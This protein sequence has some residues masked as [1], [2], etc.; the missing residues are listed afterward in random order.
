V[1][2]VARYPE[3]LAGLPG[4]AAEVARIASR[5]AELEANPSVPLDLPPDAPVWERDYWERRHR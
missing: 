3:L 4:H 2:V 1:D 5:I